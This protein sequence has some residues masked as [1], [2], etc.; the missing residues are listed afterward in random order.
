MSKFNFIK[1]VKSVFEEYHFFY[2]SSYSS[3]IPSRALSTENKLLF[4]FYDS[5]DVLVVEVNH[6]HVGV[7]KVESLFPS[8]D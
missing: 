7:F 1:W 2:S 3:S 5:G 8:V 6:V 4:T